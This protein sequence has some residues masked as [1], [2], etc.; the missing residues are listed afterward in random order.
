MG[1][2]HHHHHGS[3]KLMIKINEAVFYDRITSNKIIGTGHLFNREG[4]KILISSSLEKIKNTPGAYIIRGQNNSAHKLRIRI[5]GEDWQPDN[6][7][8]GMVS[9]SDFTNEFNIYFFGNGDIPVD[10]YLI[11]IYAT[12][13]ELDNKQGFVGNKAVVQAAVTIAAKLN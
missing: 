3:L 4:K 8:I 9:H 13:I 2:H 5:G 6:S 10:T 1:S 12:E 7:G 11:S